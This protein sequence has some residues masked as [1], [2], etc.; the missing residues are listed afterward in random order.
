M[1]I[2]K[3]LIAS[4]VFA[5]FLVIADQ[6]IKYLIRSRGGFYIC[7]PNLAFGIRVPAFL[8]WLFWIGIIFFL[9]I[10]ICNKKYFIPDHN[11]TLQSRTAGN[12]AILYILLILSGAVSNLIDRL[13]QGCVIDF[14]DLKFLPVFNLADIY[15]TLGAI[16]LLLISM[17]S[18]VL[19]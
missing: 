11:I 9:I 13:F 5:I 19:T 17:K 16:I 2:G 18:R 12:P 3:N 4:S 6:F 7:N 14:I 15:I 10:L 1:R 8:F